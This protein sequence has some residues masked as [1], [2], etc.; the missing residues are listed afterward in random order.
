[1]DFSGRK[2]QAL[3]AAFKEKRKLALTINAVAKKYR[4]ATKA[5]SPWRRDSNC[6]KA[7]HFS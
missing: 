7:V 3:G 5:L 4:Q 6:A 2:D 1:M